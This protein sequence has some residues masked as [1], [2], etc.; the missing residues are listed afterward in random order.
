MLAKRMLSFALMLSLLPLWSAVAQEKKDR[1][2]LVRDDRSRVLQDGF[3]IYNDVDKGLSQAEA[4]DKPLLVIFR[5][6]M[7]QQI[8]VRTGSAYQWYGFVAV[9]V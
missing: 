3:W 5:A 8:R 9:S 7:A 6:Q 1:N 2:T 4:T